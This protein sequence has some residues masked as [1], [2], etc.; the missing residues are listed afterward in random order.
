MKLLLLFLEIGEMGWRDI[1]PFAQS[2]LVHNK[3]SI[4]HSN[5]IL[6]Y[7]VITLCGCF[8]LPHLIL[9]VLS[10]IAYSHLEEKKA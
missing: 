6:L 9:Q 10:E 8:V 3:N 4:N 1:M 7:G 2:H 5:P